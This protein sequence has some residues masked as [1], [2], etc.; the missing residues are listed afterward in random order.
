MAA[1]TKKNLHV[2]RNQPR[3]TEECHKEAGL[4]VPAFLLSA[5]ALLLD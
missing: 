4:Q 2:Q 1:D 5:G 3:K